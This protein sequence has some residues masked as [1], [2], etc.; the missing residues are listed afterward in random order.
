MSHFSRFGSSTSD[1]GSVEDICTG[2]SQN[3]VKNPPVG[4]MTAGIDRKDVPKGQAH[5]CRGPGAGGGVRGASGGDRAPKIRFLVV[6]GAIFAA[7]RPCSGVFQIPNQGVTTPYSCHS[8]ANIARSTRINFGMV[9]DTSMEA[10]KMPLRPLGRGDT[11][12]KSDDF[13]SVV[14]KSECPVEQLQLA[15]V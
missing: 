6:F 11:R 4:G 10:R 14:F 3:G 1:L 12:L 7:C 2:R 5:P 9:L 13:A 15:A 8:T